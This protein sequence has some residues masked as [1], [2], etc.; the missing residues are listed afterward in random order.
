[1]SKPTTWAVEVHAELFQ[2]LAQSAGVG[3]A[4]F[5][6]IAHQNDGGLALAELSLFRR[7]AHRSRDRRHAQGWKRSPSL[8][9]ARFL[10]AAGGLEHFNVSAVALAAVA[11]RPSGRAA[12]WRASFKH[13]RHGLTGCALGLENNLW[14]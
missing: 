2:L 11:Y 4:G 13:A 6:A 10:H 14:G 12:G 8:L 9:K 3:V 1:M 7:H 5:L